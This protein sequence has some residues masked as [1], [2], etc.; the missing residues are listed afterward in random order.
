MPGSWEIPQSVLAAVLHTETTTISWAFGVRSLIIPGQIMGLT[1]MPFDHARNAAAMKV[2]ESNFDWLFFLDSDVIP[3]KDAILRLMKHQKPIISGI[4][5]RRSPPA[6]VPVLIKNGTWVTQY[7][8]NELFE[9]DLVG[10]GCLLIH[11]SVLESLPPQK[12]GKH[13]FFWGV[14]QQSVLPREEAMSEDFTFCVHAKKNG[15]KIWV[16]PTIECLHVG[17]CQAS[18][19]KLEPLTG[20]VVA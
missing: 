18:Y 5:C 11:R 4:Y 17:H 15:Y 8:K 6:G 19:G 14:D 13:W 20:N 1:G 2:L 3:P 10:A 9:V 16:D 12:P 7:P